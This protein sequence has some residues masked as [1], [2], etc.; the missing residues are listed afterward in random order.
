MIN[1]MD[2][3]QKNLQSMPKIMFV[4][5]ESTSKSIPAVLMAKTV[6]A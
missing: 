1:V 3:Q 6:L 5:A 4:C 2:L